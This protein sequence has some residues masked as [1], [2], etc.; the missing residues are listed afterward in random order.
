MS[1]SHRIGNKAV[2]PKNHI[3]FQK[4]TAIKGHHNFH[5]QCV[6][7]L[8]FSPPFSPIS[9]LS[10]LF[11]SSTSVSSPILSTLLFFSSRLFLLLLFFCS[12]SLSLISHLFLNSSCFQMPPT[13]FT[14]SS[15]RDLE[16]FSLIP[17]SYLHYYPDHQVKGKELGR[18]QISH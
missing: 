11:L 8:C 17:T 7:F 12:L 6:P 16:V 1:L 3:C 5:S 2:F 13:A 18:A 9:F 14:Y 4:M 10:S 15:S